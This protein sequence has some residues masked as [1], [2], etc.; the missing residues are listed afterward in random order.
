MKNKAAGMDGV[1]YDSRRNDVGD[2]EAKLHIMVVLLVVGCQPE[3][4][5]K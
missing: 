1:I 4:C 2:G 5:P 3:R